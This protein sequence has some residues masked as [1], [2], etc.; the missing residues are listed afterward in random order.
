MN[1]LNL[2]IIF[3]IVPIL[4]AV[5]LALNLLF[6][7]NKFIKNIFYIIIK[8]KILIHKKKLLFLKNIFVKIK[9]IFNLIKIV[10]FIFIILN[11]FIP[12][13]F[14]IPVIHFLMEFLSNFEIFNFKDIL[15][16]NLNDSDSEPDLDLDS[17]LDNS[18]VDSVEE[19]VQEERWEDLPPRPNMMTISQLEALV[20]DPT[21]KNLETLQKQLKMAEDFEEKVNNAL[22]I[23]EKI[24]QKIE[25][26]SKDPQ[27]LEDNKNIK[28][29]TDLDIDDAQKSPLTRAN[30]D[31]SI[32]IG[33]RIDDIREFITDIEDLRKEKD[34]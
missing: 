12:S 31:L 11:I 15:R 17:D 19:Q 2:I 6:L 4:A 20:E 23:N 30:I 32:E 9:K 16:L 7:D 33:E 1:N 28:H 5:L 10:R 24:E 8:N 13:F 14:S 18:E 26:D 22:D 27:W 21:D 29:Y 3:I 25:W 34:K